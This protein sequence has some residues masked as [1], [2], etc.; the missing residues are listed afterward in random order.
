MKRATI[1]MI[2]VAL[3][4]TV[5]LSGCDFAI[6]TPE[7]RLQLFIVD[8]NADPREPE[9]MQRHFSPAASEY[10]TMVTD[11]GYWENSFF[12]FADRPFTLGS[13]TVGDPDSRYSG[14]KTATST[15][16][17]GAYPSGASLSAVFEKGAFDW[18]IRE[19]VIAS[20]DPPEEFK[21]IAPDGVWSIR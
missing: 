4:V 5:V 6:V 15:I 19:L 2:L 1:T 17:S 7:Q 14:S 20:G 11:A 8:A 10:P 3:A 18:V 13:V 12:D 21:N 9:N 16:T